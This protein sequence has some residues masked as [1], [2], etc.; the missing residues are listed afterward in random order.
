ME[1]IFINDRKHKLALKL[2][3]DRIITIFRNPCKQLKLTKIESRL[4]NGI[5]EP[6]Q[7]DF[8]KCT[9]ISLFNS[10]FICK[11]KRKTTDKL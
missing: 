3:Y 2:K 5:L 6:L 9:G 11:I 7:Y 1:N 10:H 8:N 4:A